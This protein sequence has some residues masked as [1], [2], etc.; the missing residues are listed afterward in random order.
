M[1]KS[2][3]CLAGCLAALCVVGLSGCTDKDA[4]KMTEKTPLSTESE[5]VE[6]EETEK[7][8]RETARQT[9]TDETGVL[10][11]AG[12]KIKDGAEDAAEGIKD[13]AEDIGDGIKDGVDDMGEELEDDA[14]ETQTETKSRMT[15]HVTENGVLESLQ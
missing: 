12:E 11:D 15:S 9:D 8:E 6:E 10:E 14:E 13:A 5:T 7:E 2:K 1:K 3:L 4:D